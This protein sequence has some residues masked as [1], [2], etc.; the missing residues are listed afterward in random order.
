VA[1]TYDIT[2]P[3]VG[4]KITAAGFGAQ[5]DGAVA[6][7]QTAIDTRDVYAFAKPGHPVSG[8]TGAATAVAAGPTTVVAGPS[9]GRRVVKNLALNA[10][11]NA[12]TVTATLAGS[13]VFAISFTTAGLLTIPACLPIANG[14]NLQITVNHAVSATA[15]YA[16][17]TDTT[18]TR[19][20]YV[21]SSGSGTLRAS[22]MAATIS[23]LWLANTNSGAAGNIAL[24][25]GSTVIDVA[26]PAASLLTI[27]D[28]IAIPVSTAVTYAVTGGVTCAILAAGY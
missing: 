6:E 14:E 2:A 19:L 28:P 24:T 23:Q 25:I 3:A 27:D 7:L 21:N 9:S 22:G 20:G 13:T 18:V 12:T 16:D 4:D 11:T 15:A 8:L 26:M 17:R 1:W 5:V 10:T